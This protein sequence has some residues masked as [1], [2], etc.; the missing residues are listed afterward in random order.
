M[1]KCINCGYEGTGK[2]CANCAQPYE[3]KRITI[4]YLLHEV[5]HFF[6]HVDKGFLYTLKQLAI[7]PG[8]MQ[9][10]YIEGQRAK[11]Q[12]PF[13]LFFICATITALAIYWITQPSPEQ[14]SKF[15]ESRTDFYRHYYVITQA[16]LIPFYSLIVWLLF[17]N[18]RF[19]YAE[20]LVLF[21]YTVAF[22]LLLVII[23]NTINLVPHHF[24]TEYVEIPLLA[25]YVIWTNLNFFKGRPVWVIILKSIISLL[26]CWFAAWFITDFI[27]HRTM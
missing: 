6:T 1:S 24:K 3:V 23:P 15:D 10:Q 27:I 19:N 7:R 2:Y 4:A 21:S 12:K 26:A 9:R 13:S 17:Q 20:S 25:I 14:A 11:Y 5:V 8:N 18:K 16:L 22:S